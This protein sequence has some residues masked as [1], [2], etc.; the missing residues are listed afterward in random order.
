MD[1][2]AIQRKCAEELVNNDMTPFDLCSWTTLLY[3][4]EATK[5]WHVDLNVWDDV[6]GEVEAA[7]RRK[8]ELLD[9]EKDTDF[10]RHT[11]KSFLG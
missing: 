3:L 4:V 1:K 5:E 7:A 10:H 6:R 9:A 11:L 2:L 8:A